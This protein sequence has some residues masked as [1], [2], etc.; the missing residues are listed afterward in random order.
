MKQNVTPLTPDIEW[1]RKIQLGVDFEF[2]LGPGPASLK[3]YLFHYE[4]EI[5]R[6][7]RGFKCFWVRGLIT[8][9]GFTVGAALFK[10]G[11]KI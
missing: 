5:V 2:R 6:Q 7:Y 3:D 8:I 1:W 11:D 10:R 4:G 9:L